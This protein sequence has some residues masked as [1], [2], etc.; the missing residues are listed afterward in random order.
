MAKKMKKKNIS[1]RSYLSSMPN[2]QINYKRTIDLIVIKM[3][4]LQLT[5]TIRWLSFGSIF[6]HTHAITCVE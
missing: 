1:Y 2:W 6:P 3:L 4:W 5:Q